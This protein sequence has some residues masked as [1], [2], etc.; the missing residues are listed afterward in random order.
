MKRKEKKTERVYIRLTKKLKRLLK[1]N[2]HSPTKIFN[3]AVK[4]LRYKD[5]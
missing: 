1:K 4:K 3:N 5:E 2:K